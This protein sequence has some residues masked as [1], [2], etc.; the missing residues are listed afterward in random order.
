MGAAFLE[1]FVLRWNKRSQDGSG[2]CSIEETGHPEDVVWGVLYELSS[3]DKKGLDRFEGLGKGYGER[4]IV[5]SSNGKTRSVLAYYATSV[6]PHIRPY[7]WYQELV[8]AGA[9][10]HGLPAEYIRKLEGIPAVDDPD[11]NRT[12]RARDAIGGT[13]GPW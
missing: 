12:A 10:E 4:Q 11:K 5:V 7:K 9:R 3:F 2:K 1:R 6:D 13:E 8:I